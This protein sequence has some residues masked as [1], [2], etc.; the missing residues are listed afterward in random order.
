MSRLARRPLILGLAGVA[1][2]ALVA[3]IVC[4][5]GRP[6]GPPDTAAA[7]VPASALVYVHLSTDPDRAA[8]RRFARLAG[9]LPPVRQ[10]RDGVLSALAPG[11]GV[12]LAR[13]VRPW[14][15]D[16]VAYAATSATDSLVL[17]AVADRPKAQ[18]LVARIGNLDAA[19][20]YRGVAVL[21]A[22]ASALAFV[23]EDFLAVGTL[24]AVR[25]AIDRAAG[26][27][28]ALADSGAYG[29][30]A[31]DRPPERSLDAYASADGVRT[32]LAPRTGALGVLGAL[33]DRPGLS[34]AGAAVSAE[35]AGLRA[36]VRAVGGAPRGAGFS[37]VLLERV[38]EAAAAYAGARNGPRLAQLVASLG[39]AGA[40]T[41]LRAALP[42]LA[43]VD[44]D[45][46]LLAPLEG[47]VALSVTTA[48]A[49]AGDDPAA[50]RTGGAPILTLKARTR[51]P[52]ATA[53]ALGRLQ[54]PLAARLALPGTLPAFRAQRIGGLNAFTVRITPELAPT[55]AVTG[56]QVV[57]STAPAGLLPPRGTLASAPAFQT[58]IGE[59][60]DPVE[61]ILFTDLRQLL[62]LGAQTGLDAAAGFA[63]VRDGLGRGRALG[64]VVTSDPAHPTDTTAELF[65][66]IP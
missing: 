14:L 46:D 30:A 8:D 22:G 4:A 24:P 52:E 34:A 51:N 59:V 16:E 64:A 63:G 1:A 15:G 18:A 17:A 25:A 28:D 39:G 21:Q 19:E 53:A 49:V 2:V 41:A 7:L 44:L 48:A 57:I 55:Y 29:R 47:E 5:R 9:L 66:E 12:D 61:S 23:G 38:P 13:D 11:G 45:R 31:E 40:L 3:G 35:D 65:L 50:A 27:G 43:G 36:N 32:V 60:P 20:R 54:D 6:G 58:T 10:L 42:R 26:E 33:L 62:A 37:P 56:D